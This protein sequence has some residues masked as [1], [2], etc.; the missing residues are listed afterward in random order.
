MICIPVTAS[1]NKGAIDEM[2]EAAKFADIVELRID[3]INSPDLESLLKERTKPVIVT[4][5]ARRQGGMYSGDESARIG[6]LKEAISL[7]AEYIDIEHDAINEIGDAGSTKLIASY[8]NFDETPDNLLDIHS[9]L[10]KLGAHMVKLITFAKKITDNFRIFELLCGSEFPTISFCM[11]ELGQISR[12]LSPK[13]GGKLVFASLAKGKESAPGQLTIDELVNVYRIG[14]VDKNTKVFGLLGNPV[15]HSRGAYLHNGAFKEKGINAVYVLFKVEDRDL[16][17]FMEYVTKGYINGLSVTIPHKE[18]VIKFLDNIDPIAEKIGAVNT[19]VNQDGKL[20]GC[21]TDCPAA[22]DALAKTLQ[23][24]ASSSK[25]ELNESICGR[26]IL[27]VGAGGS[28]RAI[29]FGLN[30]RG[31]NITIA[32]RTLQRGEMLAKEV[33]CLCI[34]YDELNDVD[35][36]VLVNTTSVGMYPNVEESPISDCVLKKD[37]VVFDIIYNPPKTKLLQ[38]AEEKGGI[39]LGG[40]EMFVRQ[41]ALQFELFTDQDAPLELMREIVVG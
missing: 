1:S 8:H 32:N 39:V 5:R 4:N 31:A 6:L 14:E 40:V 7:G 19:V 38:M 3:Y 17:G 25:E 41:A 15:A 18:S 22:V 28:A 2:K 10:V 34:G 9:D 16:V 36:D 35:V 27:I 13:F 21:N 30:E 12:I 20:S 33:G 11:G 23:K 26:N 29:A 24:I 37:M